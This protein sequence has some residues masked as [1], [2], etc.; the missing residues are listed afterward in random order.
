MSAAF[1]EVKLTTRN[2][3]PPMAAGMQ[4]QV[5]IESTG[6]RIT[7]DGGYPADKLSYLLRAVTQAC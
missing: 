3:L 7:A 6:V 5:C 2:G 1:T 4:N